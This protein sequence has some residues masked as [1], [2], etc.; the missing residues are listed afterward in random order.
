MKVSTVLTEGDWHLQ[1]YEGSIVGGISISDDDHVHNFD[2]WLAHACAQG[3]ITRYFTIINQPC[4]YC[5]SRCPTK[6]QGMYN[7]MVYV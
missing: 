7:M 1:K 4:A 5:G 2:Y 6:L 3:E